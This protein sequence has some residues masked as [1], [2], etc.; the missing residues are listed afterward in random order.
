MPFSTPMEI[1]CFTC[2]NLRDVS[3]PSYFTT[4]VKLVVRDRDPAVAVTVTL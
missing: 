2:I 3:S 4:R 1:T